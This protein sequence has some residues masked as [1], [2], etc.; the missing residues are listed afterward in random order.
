MFKLVLGNLVAA[1]VEDHE[2]GAG[3]ALIDSTDEIWHGGVLLDFSPVQL[4]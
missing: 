4:G 3:R 2:P 1:V